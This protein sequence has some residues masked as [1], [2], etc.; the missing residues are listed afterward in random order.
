MILQ[1][2]NRT[3]SDVNGTLMFSMSSL[4][5]A[6]ILPGI[7]V[8][9]VSSW[10]SDMFKTFLRHPSFFVLPMFTPF[11]FT[12]S[13]KTCC[14]KDSED[15]GHIR[16]S[17]KASLCNLFASFSA[18]VIYVLSVLHHVHQDKILITAIGITILFFPF[19][20]SLLSFLFLCNA[21][22]TT[23]HFNCCCSCEA[24]IE[25]GVYK[26]DSPAEYFVLRINADGSEEIC[27]EVDQ[28]EES[29]EMEQG[30]G[31]QGQL[32]GQRQ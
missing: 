23:N 9:F 3:E 32:Q 25:Y 10:H 14:V 13:K 22:P 15:E 28:E 12:S 8:G 26:P 30:D 31:E 5:L 17:V 27:L 20:G 1:E 21:R 24:A 7:I 6:V 4:S 11:T 29:M 18:S 16:F 19:T 2:E